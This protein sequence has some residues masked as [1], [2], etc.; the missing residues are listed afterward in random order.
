MAAGAGVVAL[1]L[2]AFLRKRSTMEWAEGD[3]AADE[4]QS[5]FRG[6]GSGSTAHVEEFA[7]LLRAWNEL[8][9]ARGTP[10]FDAW[11][12]QSLRTELRE[13][14]RED[15]KLRHLLGLGE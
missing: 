4:S 9:R 10:H 13:R 11:A 1:V 5:E 2:Q 8:E 6:K 15:L 7:T 3:A 14:L 12:W